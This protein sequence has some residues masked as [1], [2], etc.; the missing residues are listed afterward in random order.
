MSIAT[1]LD[2]IIGHLGTAAAQRAWSDDKIIMD[3]VDEA[4][5][6]AQALKAE[7]TNQPNNGD[8]Q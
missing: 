6:A 1:H 4:L 3:H 8:T 5:E 2:R 7:I